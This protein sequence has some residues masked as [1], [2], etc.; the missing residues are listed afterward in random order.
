MPVDAVAVRLHRL[1]EERGAPWP[2]PIEHFDT[3]GSTSD[4]LKAQARAGLPAWTVALADEQTAG[5]GRQGHRWISPRGN[6]HLSVLL[7]PELPAGQLSL[8]PL[9]AGVAVAEALTTLGAPVALKWPN[10]VL[11]AAEPSGAAGYRKLAGLLAEATSGPGAPDSVV[12]GLGVNV[13]APLE[14]LP[15]DVRDSAASLAAVTGRSEDPCVVAAE[16]LSRLPVW[17]HLLAR[18]GGASLRDAWRARAVDWWGRD[19]EVRSAGEV[20]RG[21]ARDVDP[22]GA[23][24]LETVDGRIVRIL[25]GEVRELRLR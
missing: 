25:S 22:G 15:E 14:A 21:I 8:L 20:L 7:R 16:V 9:A 17:Y 4:W 19:V 10:D 3:I 5:R 12:V 6:L 23:L 1:L 24:L 13:S 18:E 2:A 11:L